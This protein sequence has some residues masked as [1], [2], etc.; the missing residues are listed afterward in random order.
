MVSNSLLRL[1]ANIINLVTF[2]PRWYAGSTSP[3]YP[4]LHYGYRTESRLININPKMLRLW[5]IAILCR[6]DRAADW[7]CAWLCNYCDWSSIWIIRQWEHS[8]RGRNVTPSW[9]AVRQM[10]PVGITVPPRGTIACKSRLDDRLA[11]CGYDLADKEV[12]LAYLNRTWNEY[13]GTR[14]TFD[15]PAWLDGLGIA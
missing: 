8:R 14:Q 7:V 12:Q 5:Y 15:N 13:V 4:H 2:L 6:C 9:A 10:L 11:Y 3:W 1:C